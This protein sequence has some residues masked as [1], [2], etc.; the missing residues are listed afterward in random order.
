MYKCT[1]KNTLQGSERQNDL[2]FVDDKDC[3]NDVRFLMIARNWSGLVVMIVN[4]HSLAFGGQTKLKSP[5]VSNS[6]QL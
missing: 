1:I 3:R 5:Y 6:G 2:F 4:I